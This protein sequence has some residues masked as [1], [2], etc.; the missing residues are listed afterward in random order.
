MLHPL[1]PQH[2]LTI[3]VHPRMNHCHS[4]TIQKVVYDQNISQYPR[5]QLRQKQFLPSLCEKYFMYLINA[6][7]KSISEI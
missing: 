6:F 1:P 4:S 5:D 3:F 7:K 2:F